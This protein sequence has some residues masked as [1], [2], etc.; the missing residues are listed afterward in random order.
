VRRAVAWLKL[1]Q[2][3]DGG[4][5]ESLRSYDDPQF[6]GIGE[7]T[8]SQTAWAV[9]GLISAGE[10][11]APEV[12]RGIEYLLNTLNMEGS[13]DEES[14]TGTGFPRVFYLRYHDYRH[15]FPLMALGMYSRHTVRGF[16]P[17]PRRCQKSRAIKMF[18][19]QPRILRKVARLRALAQL[20]DV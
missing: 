7:S 6:K 1:V 3:A 14:F 19:R 2:N 10:V 8:A 13:W 18:F 9:M 5:G 17:V 4:W 20:D 12:A 15:Y 11:N 16:P